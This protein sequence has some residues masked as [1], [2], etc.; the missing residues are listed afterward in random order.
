MKLIKIF[1]KI[2]PD[3]M[4]AKSRMAKLKIL[5][6]YETYSIKIIRGIKINGTPSGRNKTNNFSL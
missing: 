5:E 6:M 3:I 1:N 2:C 4:F